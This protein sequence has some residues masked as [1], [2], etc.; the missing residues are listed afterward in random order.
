MRSTCSAGSSSIG[1]PSIVACFVRRRSSSFSTPC[2][3]MPSRCKG[4]H[5]WFYGDHRK[6][7]KK[8]T[9]PCMVANQSSMHECSFVVHGLP[10]PTL[11][12]EFLNVLLMLKHA[13][14][15]FTL[16][17]HCHIAVGFSD[18]FTP[19]LQLQFKAIRSRR[20]DAHPGNVDD[21]LNAQ[22][23]FK[24]HLVKLL[25]WGQGRRNRGQRSGI[26]R[27][28]RERLGAVSGVSQWAATQLIRADRASSGR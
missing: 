17:Q 26:V 8:E 18:V 1:C 19:P 21:T 23:I 4:R 13:S 7:P 3:L 25:Y 24:Q 15:Q 14:K 5:A 12:F 11:T 9:Y 6:C 2:A 22:W 16:W 10:S 28:G 27:D 20:F